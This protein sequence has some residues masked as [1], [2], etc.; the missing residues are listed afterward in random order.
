MPSDLQER[1][2]T[3]GHDGWRAEAPRHNDLARTPQLVD[4]SGYLRSLGDNF[5][6]I[7]D[8]E[9]DDCFPKKGCSPGAPLHQPPSA[10]QPQA[11][12][13]E[14]GEAGTTSQIDRSQ[15]S[16]HGLRRRTAQ[17]RR[18]AVEA[19]CGQ[20][21]GK[22]GGM[23]KMGLNRT[24][25]EEAQVSSFLQYPDEAVPAWTE[26]IA[27]TTGSITTRRRGSSP[28]ELVETP[29]M[30]FTVSWTTLRSAAGIGSNTQ[31]HRRPPPGWRHHG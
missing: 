25:P 11:R 1:R 17:R 7:C 27:Q 9:H 28:S 2:C 29:S 18:R 16:S 20:S 13:W 14:A 31:P 21:I 8:A 26:A 6:P 19:G 4:P 12:Q 22:A 23:G 10:P 30:V 3:F 15:G 24:R 5:N